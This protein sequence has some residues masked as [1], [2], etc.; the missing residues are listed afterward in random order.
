M[1]RIIAGE[2]KRV[3]LNVPEGVEVRPTSDKIKGAIFSALGSLEGARVLDLCSGSGNLG[4]EALSRGA[5]EVVMIERVPDFCRNITNNLHNVTKS[6]IG[7]G[8]RT[9]DDIKAKVINADAVDAP[10]LLASKKKFYDV[11]FADPPYIPK[12]NQKGPRDFLFDKRLA[13][14]VHEDAILILES[15]PEAVSNLPEDLS[16]KLIR[17]KNYGSTTSVTYWRLK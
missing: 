11:I 15:G 6:I 13:E 8:S 1:L 10:K 5:E 9:A 17:R 4:L 2:A 14:F 3:L 16:W 12:A 7:F